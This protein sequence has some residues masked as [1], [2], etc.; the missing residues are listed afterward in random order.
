MQLNIS[1]HHVEITDAL[2]EFIT[3]KFN[4]LAAHCDNIT[5]VQVTISV[6]KNRHN[7][8]T[9]LHVK[10][11]EIVASSTDDDMYAAIDDLVDKAN[12]QLIK[13]KEKS[14]NRSL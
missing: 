11:A 2:R 1:G 9:I 12:R 14:L 7:A 4:K 6:E 5:N 8:E 3:K 13:H 10:G